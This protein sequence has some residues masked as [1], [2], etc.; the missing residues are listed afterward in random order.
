MGAVFIVDHPVV[1]EVGK[2]NI[3][4]AG[5]VTLE[6][7]GV[8]LFLALEDTFHFIEEEGSDREARLRFGERPVGKPEPTQNGFAL[9][10]RK[11]DILDGRN[12]SVDAEVEIIDA[13]LIA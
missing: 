1:I 10:Q 12:I 11:D 6:R 5:I 4:G 13:L 8:Y 7:A 2:L 3:S 9:R